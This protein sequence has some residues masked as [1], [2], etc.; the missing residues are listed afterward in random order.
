VYQSLL[1]AS[2]KPAGASHASNSATR[3]PR[4]T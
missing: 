2:A 4:L 3:Q 1:S